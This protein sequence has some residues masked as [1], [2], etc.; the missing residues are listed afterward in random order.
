MKGRRIAVL[1]FLG[2]EALERIVRLLVVAGAEVVV[3]EAPDISDAV[4]VGMDGDDLLDRVTFVRA[5]SGEV[6]AA[7][8]VFK[9]QGGPQ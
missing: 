2:E 7:L 4:L 8:V 9:R 6:M 5:G 3:N 1:G